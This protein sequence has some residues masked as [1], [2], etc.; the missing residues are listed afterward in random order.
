[1][2]GVSCMQ[3][4]EG[5]MR[6]HRRGCPDSGAHTDLHILLCYLLHPGLLGRLKKGGRWA[7]VAYPQSARAEQGGG[8]GT[9]VQTQT[10]WHTIWVSS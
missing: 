4:Q 3:R 2:W 10:P 6:T 5:H 8:P 9:H 1:M 7:I